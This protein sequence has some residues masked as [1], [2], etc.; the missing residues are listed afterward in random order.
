MI[1]AIDSFCIAIWNE[2]LTFF[3]SNFYIEEAQV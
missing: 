3:T 2:M 1:N